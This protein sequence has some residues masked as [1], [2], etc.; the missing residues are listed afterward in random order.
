VRATVNSLRDDFSPIWITKLKLICTHHFYWVTGMKQNP[1]C[2]DNNSFS[3]K[4]CKEGNVEQIITPQRHLQT[5]I[6]L[7]YFFA[8]G[9]WLTA[10]K[11]WR[12]SV[13]RLMKNLFQCKL[14]VLNIAYKY[15]L[16]VDEPVSITNSWKFTYRV[17]SLD[18][19]T[20]LSEKWHRLKNKNKCK[21]NSGIKTLVIKYLTLF[22]ISTFFHCYWR[23]E[24]VKRFKIYS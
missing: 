17:Q 20:K 13:T 6:R 3:C 11:N 12:K 10:L 1:I 21:L 22:D 9:A 5:V 19:R 8:R 16:H 7:I 23:V 24:N 15:M 4:N 2:D 18:P 14:K